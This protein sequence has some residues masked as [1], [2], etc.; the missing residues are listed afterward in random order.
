MGQLIGNVTIYY[1]ISN[2]IFSL[3]I[4]KKF[5]GTE[6]ACLAVAPIPEGRQ[7]SR[8]LVISYKTF[9]EFSN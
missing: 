8:F 1:I 7:R 6:V 5:M 2:R 3:E 4:D 9:Q